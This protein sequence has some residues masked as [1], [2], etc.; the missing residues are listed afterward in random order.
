M[1]DFVI[2]ASHNQAR[3]QA[4]ISFADAGANP[5]RIEFYNAADLLLAVATLAKPC[6]VITGG[7]IRLAQAAPAGDM[8]AIDGIAV[9][10]QWISGANQLVA[11]GP[12]T[13]E[14]GEGPF[15]IQGTSGTQLYAGGRLIIGVTEIE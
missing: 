15:I 2:S 9:R 13:D 12:A 10:A 5:S 4:T 3:Q 11:S 14:A 6:G 8:I 7:Y 1:A